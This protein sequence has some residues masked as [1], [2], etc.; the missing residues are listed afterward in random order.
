MP[1]DISPGLIAMEDNVPIGIVMGKER[2]DE[3]VHLFSKET[4]KFFNHPTGDLK[5]E[6]RE[7]YPEWVPT[8]LPNANYLIIPGTNLAGSD[9]EIFV[10]DE[11]GVVI[12]AFT[13]LPEKK[14]AVHERPYYACEIDAFYDGFQAEFTLTPVSCHGFLTDFV[15]HGMRMVLAAARKKNPNATLTIDSALP[16]SR[17]MRMEVPPEHLQLGCAPS[18]NVYG[19][20]KLAVPDPMELEY[21]FAGCHMHFGRTLSVKEPDKKILTQTIKLMDAVSGV[22]MVAMGEGYNCPVRRQYYGRAGEYRH[23][24]VNGVEILEYRVPDTVLLSHPATFNLI[25][26]ITRTVYR[27]GQ[28]G[29]EFLWNAGEDEV[30]TAINEYDVALARK[31]LERNRGIFER[32]IDRSN[33][34]WGATNEE[35]TGAAMRVFFSGIGSVVREPRDVEGNWWLGKR[36]S[37]N[38]FTSSKDYW[39]LESGS[40]TPKHWHTGRIWSSAA[41]LISKGEM[42]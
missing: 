37:A 18:K 3:V 6:S 14:E 28:N 31:I 23:R 30:R 29:L 26:D 2:W 38:S 33:P 27:M 7:K 36:D 13:F 40:R 21:R 1:E 34:G 39:Y 4:N 15:R 12:P 17:T 42:V 9:P 25:W 10:V 22:A 35:W 8:T 41:M 20:P 32:I 16:L 5:F 11:K 24:V 19:E